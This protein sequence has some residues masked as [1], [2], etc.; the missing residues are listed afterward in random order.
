ML[1]KAVLVENYKHFYKIM[2]VGKGAFL[3]SAIFAQQD[4]L[5]NIEANE[6]VRVLNFKKKY[7]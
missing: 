6:R 7:Q 1:V 4:L 2:V 5:D 3:N